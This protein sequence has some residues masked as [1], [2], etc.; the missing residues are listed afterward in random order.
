MFGSKSKGVL[1]TR[2]A[3]AR[4]EFSFLWDF[5]KGCVSRLV[6]VFAQVPH[7]VESYFVV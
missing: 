3:T 1:E 4:A 5:V 6:V 2:V 7:A